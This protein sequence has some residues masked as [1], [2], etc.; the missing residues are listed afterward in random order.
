MALVATPSNAQVTH[1]DGIRCQRDVY[2]K[3][4]AV[5]GAAEIQGTLTVNGVITPAAGVTTFT[6]TYSTALATMP[7]AITDS[8]G[9]TAAAAIAA[10]VG[11]HVVAFFVNLA[12]LADG[13]VITNYVFGFKFKVLKMDFRVEK[14]VTTAAKAC[15]LN[16]EI[17]TTNL[18][19]GEV[20]LT[21]ANCTPKGAAVAGAAVTA[22]N[23]GSAT[24]TFSVEASGTTAFAE[25][26]GWLLVSVQ[27]MDDA[28]AFATVLSDILAL[29]KVGNSTID[30]MQTLGIA[31]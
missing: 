24:D 8:S 10:G 28:D 23:T 29:K 6:Q 22:A 4:L 1:R 18:T 21:S 26:T 3:T 31:G 27:N 15:T 5:D 7:A 9:G 13:D 12:E 20:A 25:G 17:G 14:A 2:C 30:A 11:K 16:G 19:G